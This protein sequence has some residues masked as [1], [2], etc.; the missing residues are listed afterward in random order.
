MSKWHYHTEVFTLGNLKDVDMLNNFGEL[1]WELVALERLAG[2]QVKW[3][4]VFKKLL[5]ETQKE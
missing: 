4:A 1:G 3:L 5:S 2:Q